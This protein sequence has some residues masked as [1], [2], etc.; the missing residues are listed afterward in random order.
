MFTELVEIF[1]SRNL[2][3]TFF[4][5]FPNLNE[6]DFSSEISILL[7]VV[8]FW[9][10]IDV[11]WP[12]CFNN[13]P[14]VVQIIKIKSS[15][16]PSLHS[17]R[18]RKSP[19]LSE[20]TTIETVS[21]MNLKHKLCRKKIITREPFS[22][23][24]SVYIRKVEV[25]LIDK[26]FLFYLKFYVLMHLNY[27]WSFRTFLKL[28]SKYFDTFLTTFHFKHMNILFLFYFTFSVFN[29]LFFNLKFKMM[30]KHKSNFNFSN[31]PETLNQNIVSLS[32]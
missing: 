14:L 19:T 27:F 26:S 5:G 11:E 28:T 12:V 24:Q 16:I 3:K 30:A 32:I 15:T 31:L 21:Y 10:I 25:K 13:A 17:Y 1:K 29:D 23:M 9:L 4:F 2:K 18:R 20:W 7:L 22:P 6:F 8:Q